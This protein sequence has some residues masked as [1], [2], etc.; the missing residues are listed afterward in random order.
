MRPLLERIER[1]EIDPTRV[2][3]PRLTLAD[4]PHGHEVSEHEQEHC[5]K[6]V[7]TP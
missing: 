3:T 7:L 6:V 1:G 5:E 4:A 2:T